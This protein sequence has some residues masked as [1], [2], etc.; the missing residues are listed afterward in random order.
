M[1]KIPKKS[2]HNKLRTIHRLHIRSTYYGRDEKEKD[3]YP[4]GSERSGNLKKH[5]HI[6]SESMSG[7]FPNVRPT[8]AGARPPTTKGGE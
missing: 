8:E 5:S 2:S 7:A 4:T 6:G 3:T 1:L